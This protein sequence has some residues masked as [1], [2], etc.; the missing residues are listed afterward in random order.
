MLKPNLSNIPETMLFTLHYRA[1][2]AIRNDSVLD[3]PE[4]IRICKEL[5]YDFYKYF[6]SASLSNQQHIALRAQKFDA[7]LRTFLSQHPNGVIIN[8]AEGLE[9]QRYRVNS[10]DALWLTIDLPEAIAI[11]EQ[12]IAP[13][14]NHLHIAMSA[15]DRR[16]FE[17]VPK[18]R[19]ICITAQGLFMYLE[20]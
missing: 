10:K 15:L 18:D 5:D 1:R 17:M 12:L 13:D 4:A 14:S 19:P 7:I 20:Q 3:D 2:E 6:G 16:W 9:T 8:L 11:R